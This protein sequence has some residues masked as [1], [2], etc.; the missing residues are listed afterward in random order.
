MPVPWLR[1]A[2]APFFKG[3]NGSRLRH[4]DRLTVA[5]GD[6]ISDSHTPPAPSAPRAFVGGPS[7]P[8][9][10]APRRRSF[11]ATGN[12][13]VGA[14]APPTKDSPPTRDLDR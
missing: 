13:S 9:L 3:G 10:F 14:E 7:G 2:L 6:R 1:K 12:K 4:A 5:D 8:T 11:E